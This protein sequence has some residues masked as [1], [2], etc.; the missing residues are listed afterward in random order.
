[1]NITQLTVLGFELNGAIDSGNYQNISI[2]DIQREIENGSIFEYLE[3]EL[4]RDIFGDF[5]IQ[6]K[7]ELKEHWESLENV[8]VSTEFL[9]KNNGL[10]LLIAY[11]LEGIQNGTS[12]DGRLP[13]QRQ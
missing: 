7:N 1:M 6:E 10:N 9:V 4:G 11:V 8:T 13:T 5:S 12:R 2:K 3:K